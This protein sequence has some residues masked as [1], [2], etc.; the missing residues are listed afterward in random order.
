MIEL[1]AVITILSII[2]LISFPTLINMTRNDREREYNDLSKTLCK[3]GETYIYNNKELYADLN[4]IGEEFYVRVGTLIDEELVNKSQKNPKTG[5][6]INLDILKFKV[7]NDKTL[8]CLYLESVAISDQEDY[9][10][11]YADVNGD[12]VVDGII[13]ADLANNLSGSWNNQNGTYS[14]TQKETLNEYVKSAIT[15]KDGK[16]GEK[17]IITLKKGDKI[18]ARFY[19]M[20]LDDFVTPAYETFYWYKNAEGKMSTYENDTSVKFGKGYE[21]TGNMID[22]WKRNGSGEKSYE[23]ALQDDQDIW[24]YIE[25]KY[26]DGWYVPSR[27]EWAAFADYLQKRTENPV[28]F[29]VEGNYNSLYGLSST[30]WSSSQTNT[31]SADYA[32]FNGALMIGIGVN[33]SLP[34]RLGITF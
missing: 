12:G 18:N 3:A 24:K 27:E 34:V 11:Y 14:Y 21:N 2:I 5:E 32:G 23:G 1:L 31:E 4:T 20:A 6:L 22:I 28:I 15:Y 8:S 17:E 19:V 16:F 33:Y 25:E 9:R 26:Q 29:G 7:K 10:G 13:Y 30:Y